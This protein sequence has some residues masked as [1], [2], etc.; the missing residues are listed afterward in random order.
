MIHLRFGIEDSAGKIQRLLV[1]YRKSIQNME[2]VMHRIGEI[3]RASVRKNFDVGGRPEWQPL[4]PSTLSRR[5]GDAPL[6]VRGDHGGLKGSIGFRAAD[7]SVVVY[8]DKVYAKTHQQGAKKGEFGHIEVVIPR[9]RRQIG[10]RIHRVRRYTRKIFVPWGD[11][12]A[13]P[14][15]K[16]QPEDIQH[17]HSMIIDHIHQNRKVGS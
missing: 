11:I 4:K 9:H 2:P 3:V 7:T 13:R 14:F 12:P 17:I 8:A 5:K 16:I 1:K 10:G 6:V 15:M